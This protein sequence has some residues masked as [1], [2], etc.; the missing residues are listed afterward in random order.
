MLINVGK[1]CIAKQLF[2]SFENKDDSRNFECAELNLSIK[3]LYH[4]PFPRERK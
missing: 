4:P 3:I 1:F 2:L